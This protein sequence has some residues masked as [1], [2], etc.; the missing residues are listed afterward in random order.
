MSKIHTTYQE[1]RGVYM[2][3]WNKQIFVAFY[4]KLIVLFYR[5]KNKNCSFLLAEKRLIYATSMK[6]VHGP[7]VR[8]L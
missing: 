6:S 8:G 7:E 5:S 1:D 2:L 3:N 4:Y